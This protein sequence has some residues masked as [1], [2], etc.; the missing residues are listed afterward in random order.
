[1]LEILVLADHPDH[2]S[3]R[4]AA[5]EAELPT[6][7][8]RVQ[9]TAG[10]TSDWLNQSQSVRHVL[11]SSAPALDAYELSASLGL[12]EGSTVFLSTRSHR[13]EGGWTPLG[14]V[15]LELAEAA[16]RTGALVLSDAPE[17]LWVT[18][19]PLFTRAD[20][21]KE[22]LAHGR[23]SSSHHPFTAP[24]HEDVAKLHSGQIEDVRGQHYDLV[25]NGVEVGGGSVRVHDAA[26][27]EYIFSKVLQVRL[28]V[29]NLKHG[30]YPNS[31][32]SQLDEKEKYSFNHL[33]HAL[34]CGA[35]P[36]GGFAFGERVRFPE[37]AQLILTP[38]QVST[39]SWPCF[40]RRLQLGML[41]R[42]PRPLLAQIF[43][44]RVPRHLQ[45]KFSRNTPCVHS[46]ESYVTQDH[47]YH[48]HSI[49]LLDDTLDIRL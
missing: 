32:F 46:L 16:Q 31:S 5:G 14:R 24:M 35:P 23:W 15:R 30:A 27:Q 25:C 9:V 40:A 44:S 20:A 4:G 11:S 21:D 49:L 39:V 8:E 26:M 19:F 47:L 18:E 34:R 12:T 45:P 36:H 1:M 3:F 37:Y 41:S 22:F 43:C 42:S 28:E 29:W 7:V 2:K 10:S 17:F 48:P 6:G 13:L 38:V 33:L